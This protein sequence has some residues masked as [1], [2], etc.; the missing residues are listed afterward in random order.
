MKAPTL[1]GILAILGALLAL[2]LATLAA[3][4]DG[5]LSTEERDTLKEKTAALIDTVAAETAE[6]AQ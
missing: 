4:K 3:L 2:I 5:T 1:K 6:S